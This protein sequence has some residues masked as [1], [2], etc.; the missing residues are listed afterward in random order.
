MSSCKKRRFQDLKLSH[1]QS[2]QSYVNQAFLET[3]TEAN[4]WQE[5]VSQG[6]ETDMTI[7]GREDSKRRGQG[8]NKGDRLQAGQLDRETQRQQSSADG[9]ANWSGWYTYTEG[10]V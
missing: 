3:T 6:R 8:L 7:E 10:Q 1:L 2:Q 4:R 5:V 9:T